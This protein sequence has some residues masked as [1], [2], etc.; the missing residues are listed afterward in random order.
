MKF[1]CLTYLDRGIRPGPEVAAD[2][3]ALRQT[4]QAERVFVDSGQLEASDGSKVV[5]VAAGEAEVSDGPPSG[6][7]EVP[8]AYF[9]IDCRDLDEALEWAARIPSATYGSVEVRP[10]R[11]TGPVSIEGG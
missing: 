1:L 7:G 10:P 4:M 5:R 2:Y 8:S 6:T 3:A 9:L 11:D